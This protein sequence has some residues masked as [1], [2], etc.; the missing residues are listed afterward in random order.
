MAAV[1]CL[2]AASPMRG[3]SAPEKSQSS[4][5]L[6]QDPVA[7]ALRARMVRAYRG[8]RSYR[9]RVTQ[10]QWKSTPTNAPVIAI[11][12]RFRRPNRLYLDIEY[13]NLA[14]PGR[15]HL[16]WACDGRTLTFYNSARNEF[17][18]VKAPARLDKL[19][20]ANSLRGPEFDL[21]LRD[22]DPFAALEKRGVVHTVAGFE[23]RGVERL[24]T[25]QLDIPQE[26]VKR[27]L[28]YRLDPKEGLLRGFTLRIT[29]EPGYRSPFL[30]EEVAATV[31]AEYTQVEAN[32]RLAD[33]DFAFTPP[34]GAKEKAQPQAAPAG[35]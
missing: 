22:S 15:W 31:E 27:V 29:P 1:F 16:V 33:A 7:T 32:P 17:Q 30:E 4:P 8:L 10:R 20:L 9:A 28:R 6:T 24:D 35:R 2:L 11:T 19:V 34:A 18:R 26:G 12:M 23:Q 3:Q 13:P 14:L 5:I 21:L 25:L